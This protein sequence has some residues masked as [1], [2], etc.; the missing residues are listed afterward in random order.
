MGGLAMAVAETDSEAGPADQGELWKAWEELDVPPGFRAEIIRGDIV[1]SPSPTSKHSQICAQISRQLWPLASEREWYSANELGVRIAHTDEA[2]IP[3]LVVLPMA[4]LDEEEE[5]Q[6]VD[7]GE[8]LLAVEVTSDS[9]A[10]R[11]RKTKLWSYAY[12][13]IPVYLLVD[14]HE[15]EGTVTVYSEPDGNGNYVEHQKTA[16]G[17]PVTLPDPIGFELDTGPFTPKTRKA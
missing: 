6:A 1:L 16:F 2:L 14:R 9:S 7:S 15:G 11:D 8:I 17:K 13:M 3:D 12:G 4:V 5:T 10:R